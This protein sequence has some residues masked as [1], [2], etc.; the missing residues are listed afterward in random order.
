MQKRT[1]HRI[2]PTLLWLHYKIKNNKRVTPKRRPSV[3]VCRMLCSLLCKS[4][5]TAD[6][7]RPFTIYNL[8]QAQGRS[9]L[10]PFQDVPHPDKMQERAIEPYAI[11]RVHCN[12]ALKI[13]RSAHVTERI[14]SSPPSFQTTMTS[15]L[16]RLHDGT[17][18]H[19]DTKFE[20]L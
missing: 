18:F 8:S 1:C 7:Q 9:P 17:N 3:F 19:F 13:R 11:E 5:W 2:Q 10:V 15:L 14:Y 16:S 4:L 12:G 20:S 6:D